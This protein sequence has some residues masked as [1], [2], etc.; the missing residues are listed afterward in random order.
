MIRRGIDFGGG[1]SI[2]LCNQRKIWDLE[3]GRD[4]EWQKM[5]AKGVKLAVTV[6]PA[7]SCG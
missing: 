2:Y 3:A 5:F 4:L 6:V 1:N 7:R